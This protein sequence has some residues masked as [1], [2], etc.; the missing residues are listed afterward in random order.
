MAPNRLIEGPG[1]ERRTLDAA[2]FWHLQ[3]RMIHALRLRKLPTNHGLA[4]SNPRISG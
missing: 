4:V 3:H 2:G 1:F